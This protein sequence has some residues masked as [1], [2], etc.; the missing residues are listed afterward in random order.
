MNIVFGTANVEKKKDQAVVEPF[1]FS[2]RDKT[3]SDAKMRAC[4]GEPKEKIR[5][6]VE[7]VESEGRRKKGKVE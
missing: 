7:L 4:W 1:D 6:M 3:C 2:Q 5:G